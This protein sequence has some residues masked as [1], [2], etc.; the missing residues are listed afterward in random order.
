MKGL[1]MTGLTDN[2]DGAIASIEKA[3]GDSMTKDVTECLDAAMQ[4]LQD[5]LALDKQSKE[6]L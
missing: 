3:W 2:I 1:K 4:H 6:M 5:A